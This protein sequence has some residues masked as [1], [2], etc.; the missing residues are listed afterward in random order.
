MPR[1]CSSVNSYSLLL[2]LEQSY[3]YDFADDDDDEFV[4]HPHDEIVI[5]IP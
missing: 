2:P 1:W 3:L 4:H 5:P